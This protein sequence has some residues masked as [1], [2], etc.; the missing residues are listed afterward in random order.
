MSVVYA[1][2]GRAL[3]KQVRLAP[4][5]TVRQAIAAS[6][7]LEECPGLEVRPDEVG[8]FGAL[9]GLDHVL[10]NGDR[11]EI[12]RSVRADPKEARRR[13]AQGGRRQRPR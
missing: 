6:G 13:R 5:A 9:V 7:I 3:L 12:Y 4:G 2:P 8:V 11:V 10:E 1:L